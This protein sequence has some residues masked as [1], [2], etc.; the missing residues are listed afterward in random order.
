MKNFNRKKVL[1]DE[2]ALKIQYPLLYLIYVKSGRQ[3]AFKFFLFNIPTLISR[4][5][6]E[7]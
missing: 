6:V 4:Q 3:L 2:H 7:P 5:Q 1:L